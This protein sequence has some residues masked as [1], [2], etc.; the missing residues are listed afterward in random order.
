MRWDGLGTSTT[1]ESHTSLGAMDN[2]RLS[3]YK[4]CSF[5]LVLLAELVKSDVLSFGFKVF[6]PFLLHRALAFV[7][8]AY[9]SDDLAMVST[10][11]QMRI[12]A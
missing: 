7:A 6:S 10:L 11:S 4:K 12:L 5:M 9:C 2:L 3:P 8:S 1:L